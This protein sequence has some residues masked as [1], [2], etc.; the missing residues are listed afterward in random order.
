[1]GSV[2]K[3]V[4]SL[5]KVGTLGAYDREARKEEKQA[6]REAEQQQAQLEADTRRAEQ[7]ADQAANRN[8]QESADLAALQDEARTGGGEMAGILTSVDGLTKGDTRLSRK[9]KLGG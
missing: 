9:K 2:K 3:V 5:V 8:R 1:M 4:N 7:N 6:K